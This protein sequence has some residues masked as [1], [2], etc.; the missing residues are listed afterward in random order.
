MRVNLST[1]VSV[2]FF[3]QL[4]WLLQGGGSLVEASV[5]LREAAAEPSMRRL[6]ETLGT[7]TGDSVAEWLAKVPEKFSAAVIDAVRDAEARGKTPECLDVLA[8]DLFRVDALEDGGRGILFYPAAILLIMT[9]IG[10]IYGIFVL[11]AFKDTFES[12]GAQLP[13]A[14]QWALK[15]DY[16]LVMPL[17]ALTFLIFASVALTA[18]GKRASALHRLGMELTQQLLA[19]MGYRKFRAE[20]VWGRITQ[21]AAASVQA[22]LNPSMMMRAAAVT[23]LDMTEAGLLCQVA[24][25]LDT[26]KLPD[27]L[28]TMPRLPHFIKEM[29][30]IGHRTNRIE[31]ALAF[32]G[33][34]ARELAQN[35]IGVARQR[36]EVT[37]AIVM[38]LFVGFMVIAMYLPIFKMGQTVG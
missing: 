37:A 21:I 6:L 34:M 13:A 4:A 16:W 5:A 28:L 20:L 23:T 35:K 31:E 11:P 8:S 19:I 2:R 36:F 24:E 17:V 15:V 9:V 29:V 33:T 12:M 3:R 32:A 10:I 14:T 27:G 38:G 30:V 22:G 25:K 7:P 1:S 26:Q 18:F